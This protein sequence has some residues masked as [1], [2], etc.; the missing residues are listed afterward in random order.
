MLRELFRTRA[1]P[2]APRRT[3][4]RAGC[5]NTSGVVRLA[6]VDEVADAHVF[7]ASDLSRYVTGARRSPSR[8][9]AD[10]LTASAQEALDRL[11]G[12][13]DVFM[14]DPLGE[15]AV[16]RLDRGEQVLV[17]VHPL[18]AERVRDG[19]EVEPG[20]LGESLGGRPQYRVV[21]GGAQAGGEVGAERHERAAVATPG[22]LLAGPD[23]AVQGRELGVRA[24]LGGAPRDVPLEH[25]ADVEQI[26]Q[27]LLGPLRDVDAVARPD[28]HPAGGLEGAQGLADRDP[29]DAV[30]LG[31][32]LG[33]QPLPRHERPGDDGFLEEA[34]DLRRE[35]RPPELTGQ[36]RQERDIGPAVGRGRHGCSRLVPRRRR[37]RSSAT[38]LGTRYA[39]PKKAPAEGAV[40]GRPP[41]TPRRMPATVHLVVRPQAHRDLG[42]PPAVPTSDSTTTPRS[43]P[44][45]ER[46]GIL[47]HG[48]VAAALGG[49]LRDPDQPVAV[50]GA[51]VHRQRGGAGRRGVGGQSLV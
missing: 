10:S 51:A 19:R 49:E 1:G 23:R 47:D 17:G 39:S 6:S 18:D 31:Q 2:A 14:R 45:C 7:L 21:G 35:V 13:P 46:A 4:R 42:L 32:Y 27:L 24:A 33:P 16:L 36:G 20:P 30:V 22:R 15:V 5:W 11:A 34:V 50:L 8:W 29:A 37:L 9:L 40:S 26:A 43:G 44:R 38:L 3:S 41:S 12:L 25:G 48:P 28:L